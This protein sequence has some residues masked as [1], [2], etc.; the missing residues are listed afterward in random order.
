MLTICQAPCTS[1][2]NLDN[3]IAITPILQMRKLRL[4]KSQ[5]LAKSTQLVDGRAGTQT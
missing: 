1:L 4:S 5:K 3:T 2:L